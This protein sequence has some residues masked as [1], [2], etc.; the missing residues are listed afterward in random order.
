MTRSVSPLALLCLAWLLSHRLQCQD[1]D[2]RS[3]IRVPVNGTFITI[4]G[5]YSAGNVVTD[6]TLPLQDLSASIV[7]TSVGIARSFD[8]LGHTSQI[9]A[10]LPYSWVT[11]TATIAGEDSSVTRSG[12]ADARFRWSVLLIGA[13]S[14]AVDNFAT[15]RRQTVVGASI[16]V[17]API[18]QFFP[19]KLINIGTNRWSFKPELALSQPIADRW[20]LDVYA[21][22]WFFT[23]NATFFPGTA[24]REQDPLAAVQSHISYTFSPGLWAAFNLTYYVGGASY[25]N[26]EQRD[27]HQSNARIGGTVV[28]PLTAENSIRVAAST[29]AIVRIGARFTTVSVGWQ[30]AFF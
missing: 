16:M 9:L 26:G 28:F 6:P 13:P 7:T 11:A 1:L 2:P 17:V 4:G 30:A 29:G 23:D 22:C 12:L 8:F 27:D 20:L 5:A 21:A 18:G 10:V 15:V 14:R 3:Y 24:M 25:I 19:E